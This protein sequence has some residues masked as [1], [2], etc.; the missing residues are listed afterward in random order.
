MLTVNQSD[1]INPKTLLK[2]IKGTKFQFLRSI[3]LAVTEAEVSL[4]HV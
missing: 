3:P 4:L 1:Q 2:S